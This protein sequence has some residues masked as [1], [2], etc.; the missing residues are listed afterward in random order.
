MK[1]GMFQRVIKPLTKKPTEPKSFPES[2]IAYYNLTRALYFQ[3]VMTADDAEFL[4]QDAM[5][6]MQT[7]LDLGEQLLK[8][9]EFL[10]E[11]KNG[12]SLVGLTY[13]PN[14]PVSVERFNALQECLSRNEDR[15]REYIKVRLDLADK[16][17]LRYVG[18]KP[19]VG[20]YDSYDTIDSLCDDMI[21]FM[22][23]DY[24]GAWYVM[25]SYFFPRKE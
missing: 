17:C 10:Q 21:F 9:R 3:K 25:D 16:V 19:F 6:L 24:D 22:L 15:R 23:D 11:I 8:N 20:S 12:C 2:I 7:C 1:A 18:W 4:A 14:D 13:D 5:D